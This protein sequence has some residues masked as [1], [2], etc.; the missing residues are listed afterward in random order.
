MALV[1]RSSLQM[2]EASQ[3]QPEGPDPSHT[4]NQPLNDQNLQVVQPVVLNSNVFENLAVTLAQMQNTQVQLQ[5]TQQL[6]LDAL[7]HQPQNSIPQ[8][9]PSSEPHNSTQR[10]MNTANPLPPEGGPSTARVASNQNPVN[11]NTPIMPPN[12]PTVLTIDDV[13]KHVQAILQQEKQKFPDLTFTT[14]YPK[15]IALL[16]YPER[17]TTPRFVRFDGKRGSFYEHVHR[18]IESLNTHASDQNICLREFSKSL[19]DRAYTWYR[20][21]PEGSI[22]NWED[23]V[24]KFHAKFF[25]VE[26]KVTKISLA[27]VT[28]K[29]Q[30][31]LISYMKRFRDY[32]L[33]CYEPITEEELVKLCIGGMAKE[34]RVHLVTAEIESFSKLM[35]KVSKISEAMGEARRASVITITPRTYRREQSAAVAEEEEVATAQ[36][37]TKHP[38][39]A[40]PLEFPC[41]LREVHPG[42]GRD[43]STTDNIVKGLELF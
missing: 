42:V 17:C 1:L 15:E 5:R 40:P 14:P 27:K 34:Y 13:H 26:E 39:S 23:L 4:L 31:I 3:N 19:T 6:I 41:E 32:S 38:R 35:D 12:N 37:T 22:R 16:P 30:E 9:S 28:Q 43:N 8:P 2:E 21:L 33:D 10:T 25:H 20:K 18:F 24:Q 29:P 36:M 11:Q 7:L